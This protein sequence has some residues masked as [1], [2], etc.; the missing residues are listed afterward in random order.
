M[1][2]KVR[3]YA[4]FREAAGMGEEIVDTSALN[5]TELYKELRNKY[6]FGLE[7]HQL[8]MAINDQYQDLNYLFK[9]NDLV[10]FIPPV[11]GG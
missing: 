4:A 9:E 7:E 8:K 6:Q 2:L 10:V 1:K 11:A 5:G 3:Y